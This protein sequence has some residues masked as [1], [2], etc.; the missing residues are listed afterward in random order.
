[1]DIDLDFKAVEAKSASTVCSRCGAMSTLV[2][3]LLDSRKG[4]S[5]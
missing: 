5:L 4:T 2:K 1:M 3:T